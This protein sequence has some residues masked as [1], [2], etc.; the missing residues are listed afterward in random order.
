MESPEADQLY[1]LAASEFRGD[2][3]EWPEALYNLEF[4]PPSR[5]FA[6][7]D[8]IPDLLYRLMN[9]YPYGLSGVSQSVEYD[10]ATDKWQETMNFTAL[11]SVLWYQFSQAMTEGKSIR[12][13]RGCSVL[14]EPRR[15]DQMYHDSYCRSRA[16]TKNTYARN[17]R[18]E[19]S[20]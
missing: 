1:E 18:R 17:R 19:Q 11:A 7:V 9:Q 6:S 3:E 14:F 12:N 8:V 15:G 4:A 5:D 13:C 16:N 20:Q 10:S 2:W